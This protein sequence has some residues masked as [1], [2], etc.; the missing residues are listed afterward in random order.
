MPYLKRNIN[1]LSA[2]L[3]SVRLLKV[4]KGT[5]FPHICVVKEGCDCTSG[6]SSSKAMAMTGNILVMIAWYP[7]SFPTPQQNY[8]VDHKRVCWRY[9]SK[10]MIKE[11]SCRIDVMI[12]RI[13]KLSYLS[14]ISH[15][16]LYLSKKRK[17]LHE[18][19]TH[20][21]FEVVRNRSQKRKD[22]RFCFVKSARWWW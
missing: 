19:M 9:V 20:S 22:M 16:I 12:P 10:R 11:S 2:M 14:E 3:D 15:I 5:V 4:N 18:M 21:R 1:K 6:F 8:M 13:E 7:A 17:L